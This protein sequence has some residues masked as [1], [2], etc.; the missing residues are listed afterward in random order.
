MFPE[1][2]VLYAFFSY[3]YVFCMCVYAFCMRLKQ[4]QNDLQKLGRLF[5]RC[6]T[7]WDLLP[8]ICDTF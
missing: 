3:L 6:G 7:L 1:V 8:P 4:P 2:C 5:K